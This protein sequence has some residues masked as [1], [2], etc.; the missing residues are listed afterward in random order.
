MEE[1]GKPQ[2]KGG[3]WEHEQNPWL[4]RI[5]FL[6]IPRLLPWSTGDSDSIGIGGEME[7]PLPSKS[8]TKEVNGSLLRLEQ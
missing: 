8:V 2:E 5:F 1:E 4:I 3:K 6:A 7:T